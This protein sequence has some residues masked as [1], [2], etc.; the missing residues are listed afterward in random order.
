MK[1][2]FTNFVNV[3]F[4]CGL[5]LFLLEIF[6]TRHLGFVVCLRF[7]S[8]FQTCCSIFQVK[9]STAQ[10]RELEETGSIAATETT[11]TTLTFNDTIEDLQNSVDDLTNELEVSEKKVLRLEKDKQDMLNRRIKSERDD[12]AMNKM[13]SEIL[14][15]RSEVNKLSTENEEVKDEKK[16]LSIEVRELQEE[17]DKRQPP[18]VVQ[19][20]LNQLRSKL[21]QTESLCEELIEENKEIKQEISELE[22]EI[23][24]MQD[25]F[26]EDQADEYRDLRKELEAT[27]KNCR[28][29]QFKMKKC[30]SKCQELEVEKTKM[31]EQVTE[32]SSVG[33]IDVD[34]IKMKGLSDELKMAKEVGK[35]LSNDLEEMKTTNKTLEQQNNALNKT[36]GIHVTQVKDVGRGI[37]KGVSHCY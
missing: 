33:N 37:N 15:L 20:T 7:Q 28:I 27:S 19:T 29:F 17:V 6:D 18:D 3:M 1:V 22:E 10:H 14:K 9:T 2:N 5:Y 13:A 16:V 12:E 24:E 23:D 26:K 25:N 4:L 11:E 35:Q 31:C 34:K 36:G 21:Q 8:G 32:L 30:E